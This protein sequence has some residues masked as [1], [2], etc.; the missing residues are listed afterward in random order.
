[1]T[2]PDGS[3]G[4]AETASGPRVIVLALSSPQEAFEALAAKAM[5]SLALLLLVVLSVA[6]VG[7]GFSKVTPEAYLRAVEES[8]R[9]VP[10]EIAE[11]PERLLGFTRVATIV[12]AAAVVPI[13][14]FA[15][16]GIFLIALKLAGSDLSYRQ[17][18]S[19]TVHGMLPM[20]VAAVIG[21]VIALARDTIDPIEL[22]GGALV[23]SNLAFLAGDETSK[24][25][26]ALLTSVDLFS[27]WSIWLLALGY[28]ILGRV[29]AVSA[30]TSVLVVWIA[31]VAIKIGLAAS[32]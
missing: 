23:M 29:S 14:Y 30:W 28:R 31:G 5:W 24:A 27:V 32:F 18:L 1:M 16:A 20:G 11:N 15:T 4:G 2:E 25:M 8:G 3:A 17:S 6:A 10:P 22:E 26:R 7:T 19:V 9:E 13:V 21:I 12:G